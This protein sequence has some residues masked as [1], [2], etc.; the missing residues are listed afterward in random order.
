[1]KHAS[2]ACLGLVILLAACASPGRTVSEETFL[3]K[4]LSSLELVDIAIAAPTIDGPSGGLLTAPFRTACRR[5]LIDGKDYAVMSDAATDKLLAN[6][7]T[8]GPMAAKAAGADAL[9]VIHV[10]GWDTSELL[11]RG[12]AFASG[13]VTAWASRDG[14]RIFEHTFE[15]VRLTTSGPV[16][17]AM[18]SD[19]EVALSANLA[20]RILASFPRKKPR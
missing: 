17:G 20:S 6:G 7:V 14:R 9:I 5:L 19:T 16:T 11:P 3:D 1:M 18:I 4:D 13:T 15:N 8:D 10:S 2:L 12:F